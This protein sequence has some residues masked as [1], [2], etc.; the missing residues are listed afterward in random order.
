MYL[1]FSGG[2][3]WQPQMPVFN[4]ILPQI[5][6]GETTSCSGLTSFFG[7][8]EGSFIDCYGS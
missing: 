6:R 5:L 8:L 2:S 4:T 1:C 3:V 7:S